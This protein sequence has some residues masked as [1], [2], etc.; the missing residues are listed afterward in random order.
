MSLAAVVASKPV[1]PKKPPRMPRASSTS[2][3]MSSPTSVA[4]LPPVMG[5]AVPIKSHWY[6]EES[7]SSEEEVG[8]SF[9]FL[10]E[11]SSLSSSPPERKLPALR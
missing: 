1:E 11:W 10:S 4:T 9:A 2:I 3:P 8:G 5:S 6:S 7:S